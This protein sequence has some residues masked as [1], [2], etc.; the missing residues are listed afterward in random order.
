MK[1]QEFD[2]PIQGTLNNSK[3][4]SRLPST[5]ATSRVVVSRLDSRIKRSI[6]QSNIVPVLR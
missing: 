2:V 5:S 1:M 6:S 3:S 4:A